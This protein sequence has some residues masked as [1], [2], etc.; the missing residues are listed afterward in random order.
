[1]PRSFPQWFVVLLLVTAAV[2]TR[3]A[4]QDAAAGV[5]VPPV[6]SY[7]LPDPLVSASGVAVKTAGQWR[8]QRRAE[9]LE[10]FR[11][12]V[13]GHSPGRPEGLRFK[14]VKE[15]PLALNGKA[16]RREVDIAVPGPRGTFTFRLVIYLPKQAKRPVPVF[17]LLNHRGQV[18][19]QVNL[20]FFPVD[21]II[22]RGYAAAGITLGQLS[23]DQADTYRDGIVGF[24]DG[25]EERSPAAWR[26]IAAWAWGGQRAMD[27]FEIDKDIDATRV[28]V[29]GHS[30]GGK[31]ALWC[32]AEDE[33]FA[34]TIGNNSGET[35]AALTRRRVGETLAQINH[36]FPHWFT[37]NFTRYNDKEDEL[38]VDQHE[39]LALLAPRLAYVASAETDVWADPLG[40]FLSAVRATPV[41]HLFGLKGM[42]VDQQPPLNQPIH[43]GRIGY[44]LRTGGHDL[45]EYDWHRFMDFADKHFPSR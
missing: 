41:F 33:R 21:Q 43:E 20:P 28:A 30:R 22:A 42:V 38:P 25:P 40:E 14:V 15:D 6:R 17:L 45:T 34:L 35:G 2:T 36:S 26:T 12:H 16:T 23:P 24:V 18:D 29:V 19:T 27:Y 9:V 5:K 37:T 44:H 13:Y 11:E 3:A 10:L 7:T 31:S 8:D 32:G 4:P 39:L 1:M